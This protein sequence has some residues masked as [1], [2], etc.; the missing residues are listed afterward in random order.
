MSRE[1]ASKL[2][3]PLDE[4]G[5]VQEIHPKLRPA[6]LSIPGIF[7]CGTAHAPKDISESVMQASAAAAKVVNL[8]SKGEITK[9]PI[10]AEVDENI[11]SGCRVCVTTCPYGAI[12]II[13]DKAKVNEMLCEG[14]GI[15]EASCPVDAIKLRNWKE[16]QLMNVV[17]AVLGG[18]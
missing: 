18:R 10:I 15:C 6:E 3:V 12:E 7:V 5:F 2:R 1:L 8:L 17:R 11:C 16:E 9:E 4:Y 14:C 13:D